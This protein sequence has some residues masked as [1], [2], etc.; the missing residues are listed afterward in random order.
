M[1]PMLP[2]MVDGA[3]RVRSF[4][5]C[6]WVISSAAMSRAGSSRN[7][8]GSGR[9]SVPA[10]ARAALGPLPGARAIANV[11]LHAPS[12]SARLRFRAGSSEAGLR[13]GRWRMAKLVHEFT[14]DNFEAEVL[15]SD[16]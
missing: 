16:L 8:P 2:G 13:A 15:Q 12:R 14:H 4:W 7:H 3:P 6:L 10:P 1:N 11:P 5:R 9:T